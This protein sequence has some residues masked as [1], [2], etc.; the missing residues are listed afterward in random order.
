MNGAEEI[1]RQVMTGDWRCPSNDTPMHRAVTSNPATAEH[2]AKGVV[3]ALRSAGLLKPWWYRGQTDENEALSCDYDPYT[4][5]AEATVKLAGRTLVLA[6][7]HR[8][9]DGG[10]TIME[11]DVGTITIPSPLRGGDLRPTVTGRP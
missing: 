8:M 4:C 7:V 1:V 5:F 3:E 9:R 6:R 10:T 2:A 11:T